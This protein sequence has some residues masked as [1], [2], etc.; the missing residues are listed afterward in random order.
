M[1]VP[2]WLQ[3]VFV[4]MYGLIGG[5]FVTAWL[6]RLRTN[7]KV[8]SGRS[9]C[10][11]CKKTL[12]WYELIPLLSWLIQKGRCRQCQK[13]ISALYPA[14]EIT[15][16]L[17]FVASYAVLYPFTDVFGYVEL[18]YW[19]VSLVILT[20][21]MFYD[22]L[23][24]ELPDK[25]VLSLYVVS[26]L[27]VVTSFFVNQDIALLF[28]RLLTAVSVFALFYGIFSIKEGKYIGGGDVKML[29]ALGVVLG[30]EQFLFMILI[31]SLFGSVVGIT[32]ILLKKLKREQPL[33]FGP[34]LIG[35]FIMM[36]LLGEQIIY[37]YNEFFISIITG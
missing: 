21:L 4:A 15:T 28:N 13:Q 31:S 24:L 37:R 25:A 3:I 35:S 33:P 7:R 1:L 17:L 29:P 20:T 19:A 11:D 16:A 32:M 22:L 6:Y 2:F 14:I 30:F 23:W 27:Y 5:S 10:E 18:G 9:V 8:S 36:F 34:F 12:H 26:L